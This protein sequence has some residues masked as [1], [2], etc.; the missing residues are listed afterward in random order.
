MQR[1]DVAEVVSMLSADACWSMPPLATWFRGH[2]DIAAFLA[3]N[4][5]SNSWQWKRIIT[6]ANGQPAAAAYIYDDDAGAYLPFALDVLTFDGD[7]ITDITSFIVRSI[8][9]PEEAFDRWPD[10]PQDQASLGTMF[11][12]F[13]LPTRLD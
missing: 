7:K 1:E 5:L 4:P 11:E 10:H 12:R 8:E 2:E 9:L 3:R 6:T 13:G